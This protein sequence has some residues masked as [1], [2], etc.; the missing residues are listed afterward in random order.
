MRQSK[1][2]SKKDK[3]VRTWCLVCL[4]VNEVDHVVLPVS[5]YR[6]DWHFYSGSYEPVDPFDLRIVSMSCFDRLFRVYF[7]S[8]HAI[9]S[10]FS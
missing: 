1:R 5:I 6:R 3:N 2:R 7:P 4:V 10:G 8:A 9:H